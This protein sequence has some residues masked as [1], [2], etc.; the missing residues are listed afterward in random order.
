MPPKKKAK[1]SST[2]SSSSR[3]KPKAKAK[4][5]AKTKPNEQ[6]VPVW[7]PAAKSKSLAVELV[8]LEWHVQEEKIKGTGCFAYTCMNSQAETKP[9]KFKHLTFYTVS[10]FHALRDVHGVGEITVRG[11]WTMDGA[12]TLSQAAQQLRSFADSVSR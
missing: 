1:T 3:A 11:K 8:S 6:V 9:K 7:R 4:A 12:T 10:A 2:G 5:K